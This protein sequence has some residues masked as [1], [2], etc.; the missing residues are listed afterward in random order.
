MLSDLGYRGTG[1]G[2]DRKR[3]SWHRGISGGSKFWET[4]NGTNSEMPSNKCSLQQVHNK[5]F[6]L[7]EAEKP[8]DDR[9]QRTKAISEAIVNGYKVR[10]ALEEKGINTFTC[11]I[12]EMIQ[13]CAYGIADITQNNANVLAELGMMLALGKPTV[14][15]LK[16]GQE[17]E[18]KLPSDLN[19]IEL[20]PFT[21]KRELQ[22]M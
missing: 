1:R 11:K 7:A 10:S 16:R 4:T 2:G 6:F 3:L 12:C 5:T 14:I 21:G 13:S 17:Q 22:G 9:E 8:E 15:V 19:A 20:V 18:L